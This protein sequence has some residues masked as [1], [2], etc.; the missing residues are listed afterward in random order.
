MIWEDSISNLPTI[1]PLTGQQR[2]ST[3]FTLSIRSAPQPNS[4][5]QRFFG[6]GGRK[7]QHAARVMQ[8]PAYRTISKVSSSDASTR[9]RAAPMPTRNTINQEPVWINP[10]ADVARARDAWSAQM[11]EREREAEVSGQY[12]LTGAPGGGGVSDVGLGGARG[13]DMW[14]IAAWKWGRGKARRSKD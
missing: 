1:D 6:W 8:I 3:P 12:A 5:V 14:E 7:Q 13:G 11:Q 2:P 4:L 10:Q 9:S